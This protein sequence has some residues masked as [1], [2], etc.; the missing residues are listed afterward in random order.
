MNKQ[1]RYYW[2]ATDEPSRPWDEW[3]RWVRLFLFHPPISCNLR[4][5]MTR[6]TQDGAIRKEDGSEDEKQETAKSLF[7]FYLGEAA[8]QRIDNEDPLF[9]YDNYNL[10]QLVET[11]ERICRKTDCLTKMTW[12]FLSAK[13]LESEDTRTFFSRLSGLMK[14]C[15]YSTAEQQ[16]RNL[17]DVFI[18]NMAN[19]EVKTKLLEQDRTLEEVKGVAF[20]M[21]RGRKAQ[22]AVSQNVPI[23]D[24][25][26]F[27][28]STSKGQQKFN[29]RP[30]NSCGKD[31]HPGHNTVCIARTWKCSIC[32]KQGHSTKVCWLNK[33]N[34]KRNNNQQNKRT[35]GRNKVNQITQDNGHI[36]DSSDDE[37]PIFTVSKKGSQKKIFMD[38]TING[39][40]STL[41][42]D[43][44][45]QFSIISKELAERS[46]IDNITDAGKKFYDFN[47]NIIELIGKATVTLGYMDQYFNDVPVYISKRENA[48]NLLGLNWLDVL[49]LDSLPINY[50][51]TTSKRSINNASNVFNVN[52]SELINNLLKEFPNAFD[53]NRTIN[54]YLLP[55]KLIS[56]PNYIQQ[57]PRPIPIPLADAVDKELKR[58]LKGGFIIKATEVR[59]NQ[60]VQNPVIVVKKDNSVKIALDCRELNKNLVKQKGQMPN[61]DVYMDRVARIINEKS[62]GPVW[63]SKMDL[64]YAFGQLKL[65]PSTTKQCVFN[66]QGGKMSGQWAMTRGFYGLCDIPNILQDRTDKALN[67]QENAFPFLDD[68]LITSEGSLTNHLSIV[69][70]IIR[71]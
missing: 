11:A 32:G 48:P 61:V 13:Q 39:N 64:N 28:V 33:D 21:E 53:S 67:M 42:V 26:V 70:Q 10:K 15:G 45:S 7:Y 25:P 65:H 31:Y 44:G 66:I 16:N 18:L 8:R 46:R 9:D 40:P 24:E 60:F 20:S 59:Q 35:S 56:N 34:S 71:N 23:K 58:L 37:L 62:D 41:Q 43:T 68:I 4:N 30:C 12:D 6:C 69:R 50:L 27:Q 5:E 47:N 29:K 2:E 52:T 51:P 17:K 19:E 38:M 57:K 55:I 1:N 22:L 3:F 14:K 49:R 63:F 54:N 36:S